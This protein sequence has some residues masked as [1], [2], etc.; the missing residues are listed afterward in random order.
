EDLPFDELLTGLWREYRLSENENL[1]KNYQEL[2]PWN[3]FKRENAESEKNPVKMLQALVRELHTEF[4]DK[5]DWLKKQFDLDSNFLK[6]KFSSG[7]ELTKDE[8]T[9]HNLR[10][11]LEKLK[12]LRDEKNYKL[13]MLQQATT[14]VVS[15]PCKAGG[16]GG[17]NP[18]SAALSCEEFNYYRSPIDQ[19]EVEYRRDNES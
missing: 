9:M 17:P 6:A 15:R 16:G 19:A 18:G 7:N 14:S 12:W 10:T 4:F 8:Q 5:V 2:L 13:S 11:D 3:L 1:E